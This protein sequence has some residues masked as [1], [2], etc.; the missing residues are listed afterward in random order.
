MFKYFLGF[1]LRLHE[2]VDDCDILFIWY[3]LRTNPLC[4][5]IITL[6]HNLFHGTGHEAMVY[7]GTYSWR[8]LDENINTVP[9]G[10]CTGIH[11]WLN[12][13][14]KHYS[15]WLFRSSHIFWELLDKVLV[16]KQCLKLKKYDERKVNALIKIQIRCPNIIY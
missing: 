4:I 1:C 3:C 9:L 10:I 2:K 16:N 6:E 13:N 5:I 15:Y 12:K 11:F 8:I 7:E 14:Y